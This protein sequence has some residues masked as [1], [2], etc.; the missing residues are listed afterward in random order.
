[1]K[2]VVG[3]YHSLAE[4]NK[5][6]SALTSQGLSDSDITVID[7]NETS[8][9]YN[10]GTTGSNDASV[11]G[12]MKNFFGSLE[13]H[14]EASHRAYTEG[15]SGGGALVAVHVDDNRAEQIAQYLQSQGARDIQGNA[16]SSYG[17]SNPGAAGFGTA[18]GTDNFGTGTGT[19]NAGATNTLNTGTTA[20]TNAADGSD[21]NVSA[22]TGARRDTANVQGEQVIPVVQEDLVVGKREVERGGVRIYSRV[23]SQPVSEQVTL[24][25]ER[26]VVDRHAVNRPATD[27]DFN[28]NYSV[29]EVNATG[30]EAVV[31]KRSRVVE[32][33][34]VGKQGSDR[35]ETVNDTVRHTEVDVEN[36]TDTV[37]TTGSGRK[38]DVNR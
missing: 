23:V 37:S 27:A 13:G 22:P 19:L 8:G 31:G 16:G 4:A 35:T 24:H 15:V 33:V 3:M 9:A 21:Y 38:T 6:K 32:E 10:T 30:E 29:I 18:D 12:R 34:L 36:T 17:N 26:V 1:M 11:G 14:D 28:T 2:T 20:R 25:D 7:Q 5:V